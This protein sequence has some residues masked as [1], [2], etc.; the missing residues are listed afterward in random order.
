MYLPGGH[1]GGVDSDGQAES[2]LRRCILLKLKQSRAEKNIA[3]VIISI[4]LQNNFAQF[5]DLL[6]LP[7]RQGLLRSSQRHWHWHLVLRHRPPASGPFLTLDRNVRQYQMRMH[8]LMD[9][10][11]RASD[12]WQSLEF[13]PRWHNALIKVW[14]EFAF[15]EFRLNWWFCYTSKKSSSLTKRKMYI[16]WCKKMRKLLVLTRFWKCLPFE[17]WVLKVKS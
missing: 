11:P 1:F 2:L 5:D 14:I 10:L 17:A 15:F 13:L 9:H 8:H 6:I 7:F 3:I 4:L 16:F 12:G